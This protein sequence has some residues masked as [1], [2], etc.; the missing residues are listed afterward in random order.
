MSS[1]NLSKIIEPKASKVPTGDFIDNAYALPNSPSLN[2]KILLMKYPIIIDSNKKRNEIVQLEDKIILH[3]KER[4]IIEK[5]NNE[6]HPK[7]KR[8]FALLRV[9]KSELRFT[10]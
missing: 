8:Q 7:T 10:L 2:G 6:I 9:F 3:L 5:T 4:I 1:I